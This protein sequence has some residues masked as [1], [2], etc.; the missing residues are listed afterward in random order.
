MKR[1]TLEIIILLVIKDHP[2]K[3]KI[4]GVSSCKVDNKVEVFLW[5]VYNSADKKDVKISQKVYFRECV[6]TRLR[7]FSSK[8]QVY[9]VDQPSLNSVGKGSY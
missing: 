6:K 9:G 3:N 1:N 7:K 5:S 2:A 4:L 8:W